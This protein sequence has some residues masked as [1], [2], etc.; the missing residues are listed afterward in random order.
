MMTLP[1][2]LLRS[3]ARFVFIPL[4]L[5]ASLRAAEPVTPDAL[6]E[7]RAL[8]QLL[9]DLSGKHMLTGQHNYP[10][11]KD[12]NTRFAAQFT[13]KTPAVFSTDFGH[14]KAGNTDSY[15]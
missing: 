5:A 4:A 2:P 3:L 14:A 9:Y 8:L 10:N 1:S 15:L 13:G 6:P 12:R 7:T 11:I